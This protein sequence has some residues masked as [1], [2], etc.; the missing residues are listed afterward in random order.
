MLGVDCDYDEAW[1]REHLPASVQGTAHWGLPP[2]MFRVSPAEQAIS[3]LERMVSAVLA[4]ASVE[5]RPIDGSYVHEAAEFVYYANE[6]FVHSQRHLA[7]TDL[8]RC[9]ELNL[10]VSAWKGGL[11]PF[12]TAGYA[13][14]PESLRASRGGKHVTAELAHRGT[15]WWGANMPSAGAG[16][17]C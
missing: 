11:V 1:V 16:L 13:W 15:T 3:H 17:A 8:R 2:H 12:G 10:G 14:I 5:G 6:R 7:D 4:G 9:Y